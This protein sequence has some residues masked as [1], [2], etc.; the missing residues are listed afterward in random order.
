MA[1]LKVL[2]DEKGKLK[3]QI[4]TEEYETKWKIVFG[5]TTRTKNVKVFIKEGKESGEIN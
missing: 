5:Q 1:S 4:T 2:N 3:I